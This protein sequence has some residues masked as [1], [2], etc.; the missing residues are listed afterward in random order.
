MV[1]WLCIQTWRN[2]PLLFL[3]CWSWIRIKVHT[4]FF[5]PSSARYSTKALQ[6]QYILY[7]TRKTLECDVTYDS[8]LS[9]FISL[10]VP[11][12]H[13]SWHY[14]LV[15]VNSFMEFLGMPALL[16]CTECNFRDVRNNVSPSAG[17]V[18][19]HHEGDRRRRKHGHDT[20]N[21][22]HLSSQEARSSAW[23][24]KMWSCQ[25]DFFQWG[26]IVENTNITFIRI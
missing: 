11:E 14:D 9:V 23:L 10:C 13:C 5:S 8:A 6:L 4:L 26:P 2:S 18:C 21:R 20:A 7:S 15:A 17:I 1:P 25:L 24:N 22:E 12:S 16:T 3:Y 19:G